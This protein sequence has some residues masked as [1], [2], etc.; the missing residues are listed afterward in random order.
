MC[1]KVIN[2]SK[3]VVTEQSKKIKKERI[4]L[5]P[6]NVNTQNQYGIDKMTPRRCFLQLSRD[7]PSD[8]VP[9]LSEKIIQQEGNWLWGVFFDRWKQQSRRPCEARARFPLRD[10]LPSFESYFGLEKTKRLILFL[11]V[12]MVP[13]VYVS[14]HIIFHFIGPRSRVL[15]TQKLPPTSL[16]DGSPGLSKVPSF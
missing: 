1:F 8:L 7:L 10:P 16:S 3:W 15:R 14:S 5:T 2:R 6:Y 9:L 13:I 4:E 12:A 11:L